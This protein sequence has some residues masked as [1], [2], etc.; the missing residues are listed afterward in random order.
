MNSLA[1]SATQ[2]IA[3]A[4]TFGA[5]AFA[6]ATL[7]FIFVLINGLLKTNNPNT[8][9]TSLLSTFFLAFSVHFLACVFF[10]LGIKL[11]DILSAIY[12]TNYL[13]S[14]IFGIFWTRG[15]DAV[16]SLTGASGSVEDKGAYLQLRLVQGIVDWIFL[17]MCPLVVI[18]ATS[19]GLI[20]SRKDAMQVN[21][22]D[23]FIWII[24][25]NFVG[26]F[27]FV[28]WAKIASLA[29]FIPNGDIISKIIQM[30]KE[31]MET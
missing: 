2:L 27:V 3:T 7:P 21:V 23:M 13:Q 8:P 4:F 19:Y 16:L 6:F 1:N 17:L 24:I 26:F 10:M 15:E 18:T 28:L 12:E 29:M 11:L 9:N 22:M 5:G 30:Y 25:S 14:K 31:I 20:Q